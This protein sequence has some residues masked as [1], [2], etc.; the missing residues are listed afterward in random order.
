MKRFLDITISVSEG[1]VWKLKIR[2]KASQ[3]G[4][5]IKSYFWLFLT[6]RNADFYTQRKKQE[7]SSARTLHGSFSGN[8]KAGIE[9]KILQ[10]RSG[11]YELLNIE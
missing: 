6:L 3:S 4:N 7:A 2:K 1:I 11:D 5:N 8:R 10:L 9:K